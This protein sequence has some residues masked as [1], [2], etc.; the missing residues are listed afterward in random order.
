MLKKE[1]SNNRLFQSVGK[2]IQPEREILKEQVLINCCISVAVV[3]RS[4]TRKL[5]ARKLHAYLH[6]FDSRRVEIELSDV[7]IDYYDNGDDENAYNDD[8]DIIWI[9]GIL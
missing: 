2:G 5:P 1:F 9:S 3:S 4:E 7:M 8:P 6:V